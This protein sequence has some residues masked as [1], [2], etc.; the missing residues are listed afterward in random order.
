M[1]YN[2]LKQEIKRRSLNEKFFIPEHTDLTVQGFNK[3]IKNDTLKVKDLES[4]SRGMRI[5]VSYWFSE[6]DL[7]M[8]EEEHTYGSKVEKLTRLIDDLIDDKKRLKKTIDDLEC[9]LEGTGHC[10]KATG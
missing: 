10:S 3:A 9:K 2:K 4:I 5:P 7:V 6:E 8:K 1:D